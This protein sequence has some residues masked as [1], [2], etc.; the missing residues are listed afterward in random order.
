MKKERGI[1]LVALVI[2]V[3]IML[4]L[5]GVALS[6]IT[7]EEGLFARTSRVAKEYENAAQ[8]EAD[9][10]NELMNMMDENK[11]ANEPKLVTGMKKVIFNEND[12]STK[13]P[14]TDADWYNYEKKQWA[15]AETE[16]GSLWVWIPRF[17]YK[18]TYYTDESK[19]DI[20]GTKDAKGYKKADGTIVENTGKEP[21]DE[22]D[23]IGTK[24]KSSYGSIDVVFLQDTSNKYY[25]EVDGKLALVNAVDDGYIVHPAFKNGN[26]NYSNGEFKKELTG[27]WMAKFQAGWQYGDNSKGAS[28]K[29]EQEVARSSVSYTQEQSWVLP[30]ESKESTT[31]W[32][33]ARNYLD[34]EYGEDYA[35]IKISYPVF[36]GNN[37]AMNYITV[38][39]CYS[40]AKVLN[41]ENNPYK[42]NTKDSDTH[43]TKSSEWGAVVYLGYSKYGLDGKN[44]HINNKNLNNSVQSIYAVTGWAG[45]SADAKPADDSQIWYKE[46]G[47]KGSTTGNI[48]GV[49]DMS[50]CTWERVAMYIEN[51]HDN[52]SLYGRTLTGTSK[53]TEYATIYEHNTNYDNETTQTDITEETRKRPSR[54]NYKQNDKK[55]GDA[56]YEVS[57]SGEFK[58]N[59]SFNNDYSVFSHFD[60][61]FITFGGSW[62][63]NASSGLFAF[64]RTNGY[65]SYAV[66]F[67]AIVCPL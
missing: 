65:S 56:M 61:P 60:D 25:K 52:L 6:L 3:I 41:E 34:G 31:T 22:L 11:G 12:G 27:F 47:Q 66:G 15:N 18:I 38:G 46:T 50:G 14:E 29:E 9:I 13:E 43:L 16:D 26:G 62:A 24:V 8:K 53:S 20:R 32:Q 7:G 37:Y 58:S 44:V 42:F 4:I 39:E 36:K 10:I 49:Y 64:S 23:T 2:T 33:I 57:T 54:N 5:A 19:K 40:L 63:S 17:A 30:V 28:Q 55:Y 51:G 67:R 59:T 1:T 21:E 35:K 48:T 45:T